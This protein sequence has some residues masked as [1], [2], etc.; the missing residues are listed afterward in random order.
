M[1]KY[2]YHLKEKIC[3][4]LFIWLKN[5]L[6][7]RMSCWWQNY[8]F[9]VMTEQWTSLDVNVSPP[10]ALYLFSAE[11]QKCAGGSYSG[12]INVTLPKVGKRFPERAEH[13]HK[14]NLLNTHTQT[15]LY[16]YISSHVCQSLF[17]SNILILHCKEIDVL[18]NLVLYFTSHLSVE[19][20]EMSE[21]GW[22]QS[23]NEWRVLTVEL[24]PE[25]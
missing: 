3:R 2:I 11:K 5:E 4:F 9:R 20:L 21:S 6:E 13:K 12:I 8:V 10:P 23:V 25:V 15:K 7:M 19:L 24:N 14:I 18:F 17:N 16:R 1:L 22:V